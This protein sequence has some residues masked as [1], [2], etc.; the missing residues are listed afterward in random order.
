MSTILII[1][2]NDVVRNALC[3][4]FEQAGYKALG[5]SELFSAQSLIRSDPPSLAI[6]D[7]NDENQD[8][9]DQ[10]IKFR[11][12]YPSIRVIATAAL[13]STETA[14]EAMKLDAADFI[15]K[16][17][18]LEEII[19][20]AELI[21]FETKEVDESLQAD[22]HPSLSK[23]VGK[24]SVIKDLLH[25]IARIADTDK[26]VLISGDSGVGKT[27]FATL[28]HE[29]S[30]RASSPLFSISCSAFSNEALLESELFGFTKGAF[31]GANVPREGVFVKADRGT[32]ILEEVGDMPMGTQAKILNYLQSREIRRLGESMP[33]TTNTRIIAT[34]RQ[35]LK[36]L[37]DEGR[38]R[39]DLFFR[40]KNIAFEIPPLH[41]RGEDI[42]LLIKHFLKQFHRRGG[43]HHRMSKDA[44]SALCALPYPGNV[45]EL[46]NIIEQ[47]LLLCDKE[48]LGLEDLEKA[49]VSR[50]QEE[51]GPLQKMA[52]TEKE[53]LEEVIRKHPR[54]MEAAALELGISRTTL[55]RRMK[56]Y[57]MIQRNA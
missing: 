53:I 35:D 24:S 18:A 10:L 22:K 46:R 4:R 47:V 57:N 14:V 2:P 43:P 1:E 26:I 51:R 32:V 40:L 23:V 45:L 39:A 6:I 50:K 25:L 7:I 20:R 8:P 42:P 16:P 31:E 37:V 34:T 17:F 5:C 29:T 49:N 11:E 21:L 48:T 41:K 15:L 13:S 52:L 12:E 3:E 27:L 33:I 36:T 9:L 44:I 54:D 56:K 30:R 38:F 55:W 19:H 28:I